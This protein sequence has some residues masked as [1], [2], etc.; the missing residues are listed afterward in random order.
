MERVRERESARARERERERERV[1]ACVRACVTPGGAAQREAGVKMR[2]GGFMVVIAECRER[3]GVQ[4]RWKARRT[5]VLR[6]AV[7]PS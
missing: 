4:E 7:L 1:C 2:N 5:Y 3:G 6:Y